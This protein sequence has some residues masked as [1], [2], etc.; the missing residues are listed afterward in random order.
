LGDYFENLIEKNASLAPEQFIVILHGVLLG[1]G[2]PFLGKTG[3]EK[4]N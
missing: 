3:R 4:P 2:V 1:S